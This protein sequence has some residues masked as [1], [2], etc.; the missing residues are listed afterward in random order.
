M[1]ETIKYWAKWFAIRAGVLGL[2]ITATLVT[3]AYQVR[4]YAQEHG[5]VKYVPVIK[6]ITLPKEMP[7][8]LKKIAECESG[9]QNVKDGKESARQFKPNGDVFR[10]KKEP[11]DIGYLQINETIW[12]DTA[13]KLGFDIYTLEGNIAMG[14]YI[15]ENYGT[16]AWKASAKCWDN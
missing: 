2:I 10:G 14:E 13:R 12:N 6:E 1:F 11:S 16:G 9:D 5:Q 4:A 8:I 7:F 15:L 3:V